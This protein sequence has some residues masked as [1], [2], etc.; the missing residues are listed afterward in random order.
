[1][2]LSFL[3]RQRGQ[4]A[5]LPTLAEAKAYPFT[6]LE[7]AQARSHR[8]RQVVGD[9]ATVRARLEALVQQTGVD[10][11]MVLTMISSQAD[12]LR[13]YELLAEAFDL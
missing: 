2:D 11:V 7:R 10:E 6:E 5:T 1:M 3:R 9:P 4:L 8:D 13:S 12:R